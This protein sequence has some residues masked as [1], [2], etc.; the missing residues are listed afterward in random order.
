[1]KNLL[2]A[3]GFLMTI[4]G[5]ILSAQTTALT[6]TIPF[7]F[8]M[9]KRLMPPGEYSFQRHSEIFTVRSA[10]GKHT[11]MTITSPAS[12]HKAGQPVVQFKRYGD[13]YFLS[14]LWDD[15]TMSGFTVPQGPQQSE[16]ARRTPTPGTAVIVLSRK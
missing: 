3:T 9:G 10:E 2:V 4:G 6:A 13:T 7:E 16:L 1:M 12:R 15:D 11:A 5:A 8:H 14:A